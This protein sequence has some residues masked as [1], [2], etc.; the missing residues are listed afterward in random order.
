MLRHGTLHSS[1]VFKG[2]S[3]LWWSSG[4][5]FGLFQEDRL[6]RQASHPVVRGYSLFHCSR[7]RG[8]RTYLA[9]S[10]LA[11]GSAGFHLRFSWWHRP[12]L[13]VRGEVGILLELKKGMG[14]HV[15]MRWDTQGSFRVVAGNSAFTSSCDGDL[16]APLS[17]MKGIKPPVEFWEGTWDCSRGT[18]GEKGLISR[19]RG[20]L[21]VCLELRREA[22]DSS[23]STTRNSG[24]LLCC[25]REVKSPFELRGRVRECS[26]VTAGESGLNS[27]WRGHLKVFLELRQEVWVPLSYHG[28]LREPLMLF[29]GSQESFRVVGGLS[30]FLSNWCRRLGPHLDLRQE[31]QGSSIRMVSSAYLRLLI[32][33]PAIL[34]PACASSSLA[35]H[36]M[37]ST[38]KL[39]KQGDNIQLWHTTFPIWNQ[40]VV[41]CPVLTVDS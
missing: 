36:M 37:Y 31:T 2:V 33:F 8:I 21:L 29:L 5:E 1:R 26:G 9:S 6:G 27:H 35:F 39:N 17:C 7:C 4:G 25:L 40:S 18:A 38:S 13:V 30:G 20:N 24:S 23:P 15:H 14:P 11:A 19:W 16:W 22:W 12:P 34:I 3:G 32:F 41:P 10:F 28:D